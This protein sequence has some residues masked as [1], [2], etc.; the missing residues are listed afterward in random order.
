VTTPLG[1]YR[2]VD[3][4]LYGPGPYCAM[5]LRQMGAEVIA[6]DD[7]TPPEQ[8]GRRG[9]ISG[10][11]ATLLAGVEY[12][13]RGVQRI[14]LDL[15]HP[16]GQFI[17]HRMLARADV[18]LEGF[19]P[20]VAARLR[21]D[22]DG[23]RREHPH[24]IYCSISGYGQRGPYREM[25]GHDI[26]YLA[27]GGLLWMTG[28]PG[29]PPVLPGTLVADLAGGGLPATV[30]IL[31]ALL[32]RERSGLGTYIDIAVQEGVAQLMGPM[33]ALHAAGQPVMR[34]ES[35]F[36]GGAPWYAV[37][38]TADGKHLAI[39]A[40]EPWLWA[41]F[42]ER[43]GHPEWREMQAER[44]TW[45]NLRAELAMLFRTHTRD[46][47]VALLEG[48]DACVT[49]VW[50]PEELLADPQLAMRGTFPDPANLPPISPPGADRDAVLAT[51]GLSPDEMRRVT[52]SGGVG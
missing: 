8:R 12:M 43:V 7:G 39:G 48:T 29:G 32:E 34:G 21:L 41:A 15:R 30:A 37:Y 26:N 20:G 16:D 14:A 40:I 46:R 4:T 22:A 35:S 6:I 1:G 50:S 11:V 2:V 24:L 18:L 33:L 9:E 23:V 31:G 49:P 25:A 52:T 38:E 27:L 3:L 47:W 28:V 44:D 45:P 17:L 5:H 10:E 13:R 51:L 19:R 36:S 42:C